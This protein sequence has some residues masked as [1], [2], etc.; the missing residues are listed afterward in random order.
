MGTPASKLTVSSRTETQNRAA[1]QRAGPA[2]AAQ[3][4]KTTGARTRKEKPKTARP[5]RRKAKTADE[6]DAEMVDY[7]DAP[8]TAPAPSNAN[9]AATNGTEVAMDIQVSKVLAT[10]ILGE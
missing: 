10:C 5:Q 4:T 9:E 6:L 3:T 8:A 7:F 1:G 2:K